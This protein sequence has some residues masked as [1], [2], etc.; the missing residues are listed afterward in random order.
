MNVRDMVSKAPN[1]VLVV[2][3]TVVLVVTIAAITL[4]SY[5]GK[6]SDDLIRLLNIMLNVASTILAGGAFVAAGAAARSS[7]TV[8]QKQDVVAS[9]LAQ[10]QRKDGNG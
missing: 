3:A 2:C 10:T 1:W 4:L 6:S 9:D 8:E 7:S 5:S